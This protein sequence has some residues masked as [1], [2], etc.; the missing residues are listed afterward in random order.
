MF[1]PLVL[2]FVVLPLVVVGPVIWFVSWR[3]KDETPAVLTSDVLSAGEAA[4]AEIIAVKSHGGFLDTRPMVRF[5]LRIGGADGPFDLEIVQSVPRSMLRDLR[6]GTVVAVRVTA[7][8][9]SAA[10]VL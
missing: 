5:A 7:D 10:V 9:A 6:P 8:R 1:L 3:S 4:Q 2:L